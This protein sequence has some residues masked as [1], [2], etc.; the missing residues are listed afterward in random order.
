MRSVNHACAYSCGASTM[1]A[2]RQLDLLMPAGHRSRRGRRARLVVLVVDLR[3]WRTYLLYLGCFAMYSITTRRVSRCGRTGRCRS[4][5][6]RSS[7]PLAS[8][9]WRPQ[10]LMPSPSSASWR[11]SVRI[12]DLAP[13]LGELRG[14]RSLAHGLGQLVEARSRLS[15]MP[16]S[17]SFILWTSATSSLV[18]FAM[19]RRPLV[20]WGDQAPTGAS[21][22]GTDG[23]LHRDRTAPASR[24]LARRRSRRGSCGLDASGPVLD[25]CLALAHSV[26]G[27]LGDG[28]VGKTRMYIWPRAS[29]SAGPRCVRLPLARGEHTRPRRLETEVSEGDIVPSSS[30]GRGRD[31]SL[32]T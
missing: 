11:S 29:G 15:S 24:C 31:A 10:R 17:A 9:C 20:V 4:A 21:R 23:H 25:V 12:R 8:A 6:R 5:R 26:R 1:R 22:S 16:I 19:G 13:D 32:R 27:L 14:P 30:C 18:F 7:P 2:T 28:L 3:A